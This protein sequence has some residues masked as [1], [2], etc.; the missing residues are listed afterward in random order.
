MYCKGNGSLFR[1]LAGRYLVGIFAVQRV[2]DRLVRIAT[3]VLWEDAN[4]IAEHGYIEHRSTPYC[5]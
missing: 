1:S 3:E 4:R 5:K 2:G